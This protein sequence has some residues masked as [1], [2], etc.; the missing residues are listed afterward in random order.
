VKKFLLDEIVKK[1]Y[2]RKEWGGDFWEPPPRG[3]NDGRKVV[4][5]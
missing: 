5:R 1:Y 3:R 4:L 2:N